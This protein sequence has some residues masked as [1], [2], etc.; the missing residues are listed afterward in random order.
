MRPE[1]YNIGK[2]EELARRAVDSWTKEKEGMKCQNGGC[3]GKINQRVAFNLGAGDGRCIPDTVASPC[4]KCRRL[5]WNDTGSAVSNLQG[6][7]AFL[8]DGKVAWIKKG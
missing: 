7:E 2:T 5:H 1:A 4:K 8:L 3:K 6:E